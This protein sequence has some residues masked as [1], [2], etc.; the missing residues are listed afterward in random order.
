MT[1]FGILCLVCLL[2]TAI[3][4]LSLPPVRT[5]PR[6]GHDYYHF[7]NRSPISK[8]W[9]RKKVYFEGWYHR[10]DDHALIVSFEKFREGGRVCVQVLSDDLFI[11]QAT[12]EIS[13]FTAGYCGTH[14]FTFPD[15]SFFN[16]TENCIHCIL[17]SPI[18]GVPPSLDIDA[19][20]NPVV[21]P[22]H[23]NVSFERT[24]GWGESEKKT[25]EGWLISRL[26][27]ADPHWQVTTSDG[28]V[29]GEICGR[30]LSDAR[31]YC[32]KNWGKKFPKHWWWMQCNNF[33]NLEG[34]LSMTAV[35]GMREIYGRDKLV[36][37]I[38]LRY[39]GKF[40]KFF[41]DTSK[42]IEWDVKWGS[43]VVRSK[44]KE[45]EI[46]VE[47]NCDNSGTVIMV[48][49]KIGMVKN[50]RDSF[51]GRMR[52]RMWRISDGEL[53]L[54]AESR[55]AAVEVGG[56]NGGEWMYHPVD[57]KLSARVDFE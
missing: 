33:E 30:E 32:E 35:A 37:G 4:S 7:R 18:S 15:G 12:R 42:M 55:K 31:Y 46:F 11:V 24:A 43:W 25:T 13:G 5:V 16:V 26:P 28:T 2:A 3:L 45:F 21:D 56:D 10:I 48:P 44:T 50:C 39:M 29:R 17:K 53:I 40:Y 54:D 27:V 34:N 6:T 20:D 51:S 22:F 23:L 47:A 52:L 14:S 41:P 57:N 9:R 8:F 49:S 19:T 1:T 36:G 38:G